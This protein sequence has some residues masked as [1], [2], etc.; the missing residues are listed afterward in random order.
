MTSGNR[1]GEPIAYRVSEAETRLA[2]VADAFLVHDRE[3]EAPCDDSLAAVIAGTPVVLRRSRGYVPRP[4]SVA[5]PLSQAVLGCGGQWSNTVCLGVGS[6]L[7]T[8]AHNGDLDAPESLDRFAESIE[9]LQR[10]VGRGP[11]VVAHDLHPHYAA[12]R[13][14]KDQRDAPTV[15]VQHHHAH[16]AAV[17]AE[18]GHEGPVLGVAYDGTGLGSDGASWGGELLR[19]DRA[20]FERLATLRPLRLAGGDTAIRQ[21][22]RIALALL[23]D[24]FDGAPPLDAFPLFAGVPEA[25]RN[26]VLDLLRRDVRC[27]PA[28]GLGRLFDAFGALW[29]GHPEARFNGE[30]AM[31]WNF[32]AAP[33]EHAGYPFDVDSS[34]KPAVLD[35]RP[36]VRAAVA[37]HLRGRPASEIAGRFHAT[38]ARATAALVAR[39]QS[40]SDVLPVVLAGGCFQNALLTRLLIEGLPARYRVLRAERLPPGDGGLCVGQVVVAEA[41]LRGIH[42]R[43]RDECAWAFPDA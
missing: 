41:S 20:G 43:R 25:H 3:I 11:E 38:I 40:A 14:A 15:A 1:S 19:A 26:A 5:R 8:S 23:D 35:W 13:W 29:L 7:H 16:V 4:L 42:S 31:A 2:P 28:H 32:A 10:L 37:D 33:G 27:A 18:H 17:L 21:V 30:V 36:M 9:R 34:G 39:F 24:A 12:S 22:W 6:W